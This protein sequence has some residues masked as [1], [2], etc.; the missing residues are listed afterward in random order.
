MLNAKGLFKHK[1]GIK[2]RINEREPRT[3]CLTE[4]H[5]TEEVEVEIHLNNYE[6]IRTN[7]TNYRTGGVLTYIRK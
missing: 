3:L 2:K 6:V 4:T 7:T 5:A 1:D